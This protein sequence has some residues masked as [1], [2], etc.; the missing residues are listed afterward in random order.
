[1]FSEVRCFKR[2]LNAS[3]VTV[4]AG[5]MGVSPSSRKIRFGVS[6]LEA[7]GA[8]QRTPDTIR[9]THQRI[10]DIRAEYKHLMATPHCPMRPKL[11][12]L[13]ADRDA[14]PRR[15]Q[16][17]LERY[18]ITTLSKLHFAIGHVQN[19]RPSPRSYVRPR[20]ASR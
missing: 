13:I 2:L 14:P 9:H 8:C 15:M 5:C 6:A 19:F 16:L 1:M 20:M 10:R 11:T 17:S 4:A 7:N 12:S 18:H 3:T